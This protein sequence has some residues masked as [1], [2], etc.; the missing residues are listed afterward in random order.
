MSEQLTAIVTGAGSARGIGRAT[1]RRL[2]AQGWAVGVIDLDGAA[3]VATAEEI[4]AE[5]GVP[6]FGVAADV[7]DEASVDAAVTAI[8]A[9]LPPLG[10]L[11]NIA[12]ITSPTRFFNTTLEEW[13]RVMSINAT[14]TYVVSKRVAATLVE[15]GY[16]RIANMSSVSAVRGGGVFGGVPYSAA[17]AAILGLTR[18]LARELGPT[19]VT[20][21]AVTPG[22][23]DTDI[24]AGATS[25]EL[26]AKLSADVPVGRQA[27]PDEVAALFAFLLSPDAG[28]LTGA[29]YD[30][31]GGSH[32]Y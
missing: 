31:N 24:R 1:A 25:P 5:F 27:T 16:G 8:E 14:G 28:Y 3:A 22:V 21:N 12:G 11:A 23:V 13:N 6:T 18:A 32:I 26:E 19:G 20:V 10:A 30:I 17:K 15:R 7:T 2:A 4:A 9:A 29:T